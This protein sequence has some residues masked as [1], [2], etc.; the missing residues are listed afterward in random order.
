MQLVPMRIRSERTFSRTH[1]QRWRKRL[2]P[3]GKKAQNVQD[4]AYPK[5]GIVIPPF[6]G[7]Y[8]LII[9]TVALSV[10]SSPSPLRGIP[11]AISQDRPLAV[12]ILEGTRRCAIF[13]HTTLRKS[14]PVHLPGP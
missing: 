3:L 2:A 6:A 13:C 8:N 11:S 9:V 1:F 10:C 7:V 5:S 12:C 4:F 14:V